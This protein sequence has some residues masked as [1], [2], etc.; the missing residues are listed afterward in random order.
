MIDREF[1]WANYIANAWWYFAALDINLAIRCYHDFMSETVA[2]ALISA[3]SALVGVAVTELFELLKRKSEEMRWYADYFLPKKFEAISMLYAQLQTS[4]T[5]LSKYHQRK[6][7]NKQELEKEVIDV[8]NELFH[9]FHLANIYLSDSVN[10][11][12][13][14]YLDF[15][16]TAALYIHAQFEPIIITHNGKPANVIVDWPD[17]KNG[18]YAKAKVAL[19]KVLTPKFLTKFE[20]KWEGR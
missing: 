15:S 10:K 12:V 3:S 4:Y 17:E 16:T 11:T 19:A 5:A 9:T 7:A 14:E 6:P 1:S 2:V 18:T 20:S 13:S 8:I